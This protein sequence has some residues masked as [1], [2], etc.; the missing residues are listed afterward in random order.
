MQISSD[1]ELFLK[2]MEFPATRDDLVR[3]ASHDGVG[4]DDLLALDTLPDV[5]YD[6]RSRVRHALGSAPRQGM[7]VAA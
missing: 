3:E 1:L 6:S 4:A 7:L 2:G 5:T